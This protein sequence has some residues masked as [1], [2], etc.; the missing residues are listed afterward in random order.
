[1]GTSFAQRYIQE[2]ETFF[3]GIDF[4]NGAHGGQRDKLTQ[5][6]SNRSL[7][8]LQLFVKRALTRFLETSNRIFPTAEEA[9]YTWLFCKRVVHLVEQMALEHGCQ[10]YHNLHETIFQ[11]YVLMHCHAHHLSALSGRVW[12][13][14]YTGGKSSKSRFYTVNSEK[15][16]QS[17]IDF[18]TVNTLGDISGRDG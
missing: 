5:L 17:Q 14:L 10:V 13:L 6:W 9:A 1:M 3:F 2:I 4:H 12:P 15:V 16:A 11:R 18:S 8:T 7:S